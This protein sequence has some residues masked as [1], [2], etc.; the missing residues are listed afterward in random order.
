MNEK[1]RAILR[2]HMEKAMGPNRTR[3]GIFVDHNCSYCDN[4][5]KPCREGKAGGIGCEFPHARND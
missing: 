2:E 3:I 1:A 4:G 5:R